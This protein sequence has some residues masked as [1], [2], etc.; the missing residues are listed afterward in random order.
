MN[1]QQ[2]RIVFEVAQE[3]SI[4]RAAAKL[5]ISQPNA[6]SSIHALE[7]ELGYELFV[8]TNTGIRLTERGVQFMEHAKR[9]LAEYRAMRDL[10]RGERVCRLRLGMMNYAPAAEAFVRFAGEY[11]DKQDA[12]VSCANI[13]CLRGIEALGNMQLDLVVGLLERSQ[14]EPVMQA[15]ENRELEL[16]FIRNVALNINLRRGHPWLENGARDFAALA[17]YPYVGY[18]QLPGMIDTVERLT[19]SRIDCRYSILVDERETRCRLVGMTDAFSFGC[20]LPRAALEKYGIVS[21]CLSDD[22]AGIYSV[23]RRGG[24]QDPEIKRYL[25]LL[26]GELE[27]I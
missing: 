18:S 3:G 16:R 7:K 6:S 25:E 14:L 21:V 26:D 13:S 8:R 9:L 17:Q 11:A 2:C 20:K 4:S 19:G 12:D 24:K 5:Y 27:E 15:A 23:T 22:A 10:G 1:I